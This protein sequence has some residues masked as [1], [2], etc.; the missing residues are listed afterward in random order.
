MMR[1]R[2]ALRKKIRMHVENE[3]LKETY[4]A[5]KRKLEYQI[6]HDN[7]KNEVT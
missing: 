6:I 4:L 5:E 2:E 7:L 1:F 3:S